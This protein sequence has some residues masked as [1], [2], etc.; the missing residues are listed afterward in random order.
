MVIGAYIVGL[1]VAL[2]LKF[3]ASSFILKEKGYGIFLL[4]MSRVITGLVIALIS[5]DINESIYPFVMGAI[6]I[7]WIA[8]TIS[9]LTIY[10][11][12]LA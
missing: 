6:L 12:K 1:M 5:F 3:K 9:E 11:K 4:W 10:K 2:I 7:Y 8:I